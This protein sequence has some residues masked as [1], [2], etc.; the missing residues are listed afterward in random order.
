MSIGTTCLVPDLGIA[1]AFNAGLKEPTV[2]LRWIGLHDEDISRLQQPIEGE[3]NGQSTTDLS[4][5]TTGAKYI[6]PADD[7]RPAD[8]IC[9]ERP[10]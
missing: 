1:F 9:P 2:T 4:L 5:P 8:L 6:S 3:S 7:R 10:E